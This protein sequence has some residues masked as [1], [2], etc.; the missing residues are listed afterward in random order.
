MDYRHQ[1]ICVYFSGESRQGSFINHPDHRFPDLILIHPVSVS[2]SPP[3]AVAVRSGSARAL[4]PCPPAGRDNSASGAATVSASEDAT[5]WR[6]SR[7][8]EDARSSLEQ[9]D[10]LAATMTMSDEVESTPLETSQL[11]PKNVSVRQRRI[12]L[13]GSKAQPLA[14]ALAL[15]GTIGAVFTF[16][17]I[18]RPRRNR[19]AVSPFPP[20]FFWGAAT[21]AYQIE[22]GSTAGGRGPSIWDT[23]C[24][25]SESNCNND[26]GDI[27]DDHYHLWKEDMVS[28]HNIVYTWDMRW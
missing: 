2:A 20:G 24:V 12:V 25:E 15:L 22:G 3:R 10:Q 4:R 5:A 28:R 19:Y 27:T 14:L 7:P 18:R 26:T 1:K 6:G 16:V 9:S 8:G 17:S 21:S 11:L 13:L 23:W